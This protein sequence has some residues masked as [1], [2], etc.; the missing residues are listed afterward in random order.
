M[1]MR[2]GKVTQIYR[3]TGKLKVVYEDTN[4]ASL[5]LSMLTMNQEYS[6]PNV[7][8]KVITIHMENGKS[9]GFVLGTYYG[10]SMLPK[11]DKGYRKD[12]ENGVFMECDGG[13]YQI[14]ADKIIMKCNYGQADL[15]DILKRIE[16]IEDHLGLMHNI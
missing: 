15:E 7:G 6:M 8:D 5:K 2:I 11:T 10:G 3:D 13:T 12:Y 16:R 1:L 9:K 14:T 4:C